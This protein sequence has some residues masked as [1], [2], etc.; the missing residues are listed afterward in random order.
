MHALHTFSTDPLRLHSGFSA[1]AWAAHQYSASSFDTFAEQTSSFSSTFSEPETAPTGFYYRDPELHPYGATG[2]HRF[3][4][5]T[6]CDE[7][8][9]PAWN[10]RALIESQCFALKSITRQLLAPPDVDVKAEASSSSPN[11]SPPA[12]RRIYIHGT[13]AANPSLVSTLSSSL[14]APVIAP[15]A[16]TRRPA[17]HNLTVSSIDSHS[18]SIGSAM[19]AYWAWRRNTHG[20][21]RSFIETLI[22]VQGRTRESFALLLKEPETE[23]AEMYE[24]RLEGWE[25]L[26]ERVLGEL[27]GGEKA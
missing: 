20:S 14:N 15:P 22:G 25:K 16:L 8:Q 2:V 24:R 4:G 5:L 7:F 19:A 10:P 9:D 26:R 21:E 11:P 12:I 13:E 6:P 18:P 17:S 1:R 27:K 3:E 23:V